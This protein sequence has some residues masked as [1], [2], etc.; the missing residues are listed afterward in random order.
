MDASVTK[1]G[2]NKYLVV[3]SQQYLQGLAENKYA[4]LDEVRTIETETD[5]PATLSIGVGAGGKTPAQTEKY[6]AEVLSKFS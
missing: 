4:I 5:F 3:F 6:S 2:E 1:I